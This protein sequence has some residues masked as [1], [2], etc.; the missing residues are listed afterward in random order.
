MNTRNGALITDVVEGSPAEKSGLQEG[1]LIITFNDELISNPA[2]LK[3]VVSLS[4]PESPSKV[5]IIRDGKNKTIKVRLEELPDEPQ[6]LATKLKKESNEFG[7]RLKKLT[8]SLRKKYG[9]DNEDALVVTNINLDGE[10]YQ[11]GIREGDIIKRVGTQKISTVSQFNKLV[12][13]GRSKG[14]ILILVK[15]P[16]GSSRFYTLEL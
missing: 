4:S 15:K 7:F 16:N 10:A 8:D 2:N 11:K 1:D 6:Q 3:N 9:Y 13:A 14:A 5:K 12:E